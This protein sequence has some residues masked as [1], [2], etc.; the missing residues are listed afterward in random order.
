MSISGISGSLDIEGLV[1]QYRSIEIIPRT[2][3][4]DRQLSLESRR[5]ALTE[6]NSKLSALYSQSDKFSDS[7]THVFDVKEGVSSDESALTTQ[8]E[9]GDVRDVLEL[10]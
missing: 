7:L 4:E 5:D 1:A 2:P 10:S 9:I 6:L 8:K 3:L